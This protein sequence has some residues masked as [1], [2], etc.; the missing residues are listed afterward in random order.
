MV[1]GALGRELHDWRPPQVADFVRIKGSGRYGPGQSE[2]NALADIRAVL[3]RLEARHPGL[4]TKVETERV[5]G[6]PMMP[7]FEVAKEAR[8]VRAINAA[9]ETVPRRTAAHRRH[10]PRPAFFGTDAGHFYA[11]A[12]MEG[13]VCGPGGKYNTMPRRTGR[14]R[15]PTWT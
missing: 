2:A 6:R 10:H 4:K 9:Y 5:S 1:R 7:A 13:V 3:A 8:I 12:G 15:R 11:E 14:S